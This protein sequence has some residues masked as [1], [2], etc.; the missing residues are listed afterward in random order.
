MNHFRRRPVLQLPSAKERRSRTIRTL[1][2]DIL[3]IVFCVLMIGAVALSAG[4]FLIPG[5]FWFGFTFTILLVA[6]PPVLLFFFPPRRKSR[7]AAG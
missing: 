5:Y 6:G 7:N 3:A 4:L 1:C 2:I